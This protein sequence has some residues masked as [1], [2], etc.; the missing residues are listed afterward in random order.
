MREWPSTCCLNHASALSTAHGFPSNSVDI[1]RELGAVIAGEK[2]GIPPLA[3]LGNSC[4]VRVALVMSDGGISRKVR[5]IL[6]ANIEEQNVLYAN[7]V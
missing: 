1:L 4:S 5:A 3:A 2:A 7:E 6:D